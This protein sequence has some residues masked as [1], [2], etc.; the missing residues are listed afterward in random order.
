MTTYGHAVAATALAAVA[1]GGVAGCAAPPPPAHHAAGHAQADAPERDDNPASPPEESNRG[2]ASQGLRPDIP[3]H[4]QVDYE[5]LPHGFSRFDEGF[6]LVNVCDEE[7]VKHYAEIGMEPTLFAPLAML[8]FDQTS[9]SCSRPDSGTRPRDETEVLAEGINREEI[10]TVL[11]QN[12]FGDAEDT[13]LPGAY[14]L[15]YDAT[16]RNQNNCQ[17]AIDSPRG[18]IAVTHYGARREGRVQEH[19]QLARQTLEKL[20]QDEVFLRKIYGDDIPL[21]GGGTA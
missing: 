11:P 3:F 2:A 20:Y 1:L 16:G 8:T 13:W 12:F 5:R 7:M 17:I 15:D 9:W 21:K 19:C 14:Y 6:E 4:E 10:A 18:R